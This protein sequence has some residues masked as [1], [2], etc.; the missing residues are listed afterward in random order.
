MYDDKLHK[1]SIIK[2]IIEQDKL[3][4]SFNNVFIPKIFSQRSGVL[5]LSSELDELPKEVYKNVVIG[6]HHFD[7]V[8][9][10]YLKWE[11]ENKT[12]KDKKYPII[13]QQPPKDDV[14]EYSD[15]W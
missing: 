6:M 13:D 10:E 15:T 4:P 7:E 8:E 3:D 9:K 5:D 2:S 11:N 12:K 1:I 14:V